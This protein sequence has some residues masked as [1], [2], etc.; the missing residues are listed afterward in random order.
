MT[1]THSHFRS[2]EA[3]T[4][5]HDRHRP[6]DHPRFDQLPAGLADPPTIVALGPFDDPEHAEQL[7]AAFTMVRQVR[8]AQL[9]LVGTGVQRGTVVRRAAADNVET[10]VHL[11]E[12]PSGQQWTDLL[13]AADFVVPS[14]TSGVTTLLDVLAAG[15]A[16]VVPEHPATVG[17]VLPTSAGLVYRRGDVNGMAQA[18]LRLLTTPELRNGMATRARDAATRSRAETDTKYR[19]MSSAHAARR[20]RIPRGSHEPN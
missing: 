15:R 19:R 1:D 18:M 10:D 14:S 7:A 17:L 13:V 16:V 12:D 8:Q 3:G 2:I 11:I 6:L 4:P 9:L 5:T 20:F